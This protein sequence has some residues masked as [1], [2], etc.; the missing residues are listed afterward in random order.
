MAEKLEHEN[1]RALL[2]EGDFSCFIGNLKACIWNVKVL[3]ECVG[4]ERLSGCDLP[5]K[6]CAIDNE[7]FGV[8]IIPG[9]GS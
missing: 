2:E 7:N 5:P 8:I 9:G 4:M 6:N 3:P 1:I